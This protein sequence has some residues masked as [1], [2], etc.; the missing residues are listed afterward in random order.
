MFCLL[1]ILIEFKPLILNPKIVLELPN[2]LVAVLR[3]LFLE[4]FR[5][6][7]MSSAFW[8]FDDWIDEKKNKYFGNI[9]SGN[10]I[11]CFFKANDL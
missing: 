4:L 8:D 10:S 6:S 7:T 2:S 1:P 3:D 11:Q 5:I 9:F